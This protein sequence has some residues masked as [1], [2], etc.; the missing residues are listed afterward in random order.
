MEVYILHN[1]IRYE[2]VFRNR[3]NDKVMEGE[4]RAWMRKCW[5]SW[6]TKRFISG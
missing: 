5:E 2:K 3:I 6:Q 1:Y 4:T